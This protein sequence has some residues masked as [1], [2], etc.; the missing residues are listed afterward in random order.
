M[1]FMDGELSHPVPFTVVPLKEKQ[2][3][4]KGLKGQW[5]EADTAAAAAILRKLREQL[6]TSPC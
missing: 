5:A 1:D 6:S 3:P 4:L 2:G